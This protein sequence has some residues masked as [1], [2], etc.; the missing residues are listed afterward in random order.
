FTH[1]VAVRHHAPG[2]A[3]STVATVVAHGK[4]MPVRY[5]PFP[6]RPRPDHRPARYRR[7]ADHPLHRGASV[8][9]LLLR[10][11]FLRPPGRFTA[12]LLRGYGLTMDAELTVAVNN[13]VTGQTDDPFDE[14]TR[15]IGREKY[16]HITAGR[17]TGRN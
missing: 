15:I 16:H 12:Q 17:L 6:F 7:T 14:I 13:M 3:V 10:H 5:G 1:D 9:E 8:T 4:E 11:D 2:A